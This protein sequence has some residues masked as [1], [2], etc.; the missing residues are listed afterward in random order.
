MILR[1]PLQL[2]NSWTDLHFI[3]QSIILKKALDEK[4]CKMISEAAVKQE[5]EVKNRHDIEVQSSIFVNLAKSRVLN[6][7]DMKVLL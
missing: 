2:S 7:E 6:Q 5:L 3:F 1:Q 4:C